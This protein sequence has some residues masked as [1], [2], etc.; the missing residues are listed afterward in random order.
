MRVLLRQGRLILIPEH[1]AEAQTLAEWRAH[2]QFAF[3]SV[4]NS[5]TGATLLSL[6]PADEAC[7]Q[8]VQVSSASPSPINLIANFAATPFLLDGIRYSLQ[9]EAGDQHTRH[10]ASN[11]RN[12][13]LTQRQHHFIG[14]NAVPIQPVTSTGFST[15]SA[16]YG[17]SRLIWPRRQ[18][19]AKRNS[20]SC[21]RF[22]QRRAG[23]DHT[24]EPTKHS[25]L[26]A[27][28]R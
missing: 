8:P 2:Q 18:S 9:H 23:H 5:G 19:R 20:T 10:Q 22:S 7:R 17:H 12:R 24:T 14:Q 1:D 11:G 25:L 16:G 4:P 15:A 6:G 26:E 3:T 27:R 13:C 28:R 21:H